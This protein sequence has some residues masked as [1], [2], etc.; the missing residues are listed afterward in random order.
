MSK[1]HDHKGTVLD[2]EKDFEPTDA[3]PLTDE[4]EETFAMVCETIARG[5]IGLPMPDLGRIALMR[6][7]FHGRDEAVIVLTNDDDEQSETIDIRPLALLV[8]EEM[9]REM[10]PR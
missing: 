4:E 2:V 1:D 9:F 10:N 6:V 8:T 3:T 7:K 5:A